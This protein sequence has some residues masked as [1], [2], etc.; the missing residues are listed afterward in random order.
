VRREGR[1]TPAQARALKSLWPRY[2]VEPG[3]GTVDLDAVFGRRAPR[4]AEVGFGNGAALLALAAERPDT[5]FLGIEVHGPGVG[6][7]L[8]GLDE[9]GIANVRV[10]REDAVQVFAARLPA[11]SL[12]AVH[13]F[14]PDPW[15][16]KR[17]HKRRLI[18][19]AF[20]AD[21]AR[22]LRPDGRLHVATD[23]ED[24][25]AHILEAAAVVPELRNLGGADGFS[26]RPDY[27]PLTKYEQRGRRLGH[28]V[29][30]IIFEKTEA[31]RAED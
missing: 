13:V 24:Y 4:V 12:D 18:Q 7:L 1:I 16:K 9:R 17:H 26:P 14:F 15:P 8:R 23:W 2:G 29:R 3:E 20:L 31:G 6:A 5:D 19:P 27:R 22:V 30:D 11:G 28:V 21:V 25:A 10:L